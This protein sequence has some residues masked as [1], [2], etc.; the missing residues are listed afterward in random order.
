MLWYSEYKCKNHT[1]TREPIISALYEFIV[2]IF[3]K[4]GLNSDTIWVPFFIISIH[5]PPL[6]RSPLDPSDDIIREASVCKWW[7]RGSV[8]RLCFV[9]RVSCFIHSGLDDNHSSQVSGI[10]EVYVG[11]LWLIWMLKV[12][13]FLVDSMG[14]LSRGIVEQWS[15]AYKLLC[16]LR[17]VI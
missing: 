4:F 16:T 14:K 9:F 1:A 17:R 5:P 8:S 11:M 2:L 10:R 12:V 7:T 3:P 15:N 6:C 13:L